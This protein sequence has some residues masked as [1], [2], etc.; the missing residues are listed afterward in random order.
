MYII[1]NNVGKTQCYSYAKDL[2]SIDPPKLRLSKKEKLF[3]YCSDKLAMEVQDE[4]YPFIRVIIVN[5][6]GAFDA[7][8]RRVTHK[9]VM[10]VKRP[11][12]LGIPPHILQSCTLLQQI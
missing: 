5:K 7:K 3:W 12:S 2:E 6:Y 11:I 10:R 4:F 1:L 9:F 8:G